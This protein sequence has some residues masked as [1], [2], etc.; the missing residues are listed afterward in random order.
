MI[1]KNRNY[2]SI[3]LALQHF[4]EKHIELIE[5]DD[6][7]ALLRQF[8]DDGAAGN[9]LWESD[10]ID[11]CDMVL[12]QTL[13]LSADY[14]T[15]LRWKVLDDVLIDTIDWYQQRGYKQIQYEDFYPA[16]LLGKHGFTTDEIE[17][18]ID[19]YSQSKF[20]NSN[21][22]FNYDDDSILYDSYFRIGK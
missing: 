6:F 15:E 17:E 20:K 14:I 12:E 4:I 19:K 8:Y 13:E 21:F 1:L 5:N 2:N 18:Y 16:V 22:V 7:Y 3:S 9:D 11:L 10:Y